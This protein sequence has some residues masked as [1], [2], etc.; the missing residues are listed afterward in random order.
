MPRYGHWSGQ[1]WRAAGAPVGGRGAGGEPTKRLGRTG[2]GSQKRRSGRA[3]RIIRNVSV[4]AVVA[5]LIVGGFVWYQLDDLSRGM[6]TSRALQAAPLSTDGGTNVL[7]MGLDSRKDQQG[8]DLPPQIL[9]Q[10]HAGD[11]SEG[12]YNTNTLILMHLPA[13]GGPATAFSIPRDDAVSIPGHG[14]DKIKEAYGLAKAQAETALA[15]H[16][17]TDPH[18]RETQSRDAGR[19]ATLDAVRELTGVPIDHFAEVN[20]AGFYDI[21]TALNGVHVCLNHPVQ[22]TYSGAN[23]PAG[24]QTLNGSQALSFVRQ[25]HG[26]PNGD[27]D[28]THRQQAFLASASQ[29]LHNPV[30][31][32]DIS[33]MLSVKDAAKRDVVMDNGWGALSF[34]WDMDNLTGGNTQFQTLPIKRYGKVDGKDVNIVDP[35]QLRSLVAAAFGPKPD[36]AGEPGPERAPRIVQPVSFN[37]SHQKNM[38]EQI[39]AGPPVSGSDCVN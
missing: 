3:R 10:L 22:D 5:L 32:L 30:T 31:W 34:A 35:A 4:V 2:R 12:G 9:A 15:K 8:N 13:G 29:S 18:Q 28:R 25:R 24:R 33:K 11:G 1:D 6:A 16:G 39:P 38:P 14:K 26:L 7:L 21:A 17:V 20:L 37:S 36:A 27:L 19:K 23:F